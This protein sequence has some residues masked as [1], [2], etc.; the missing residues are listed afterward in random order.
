[1]RKWPSFLLAGLVGT[2]LATPAAAINLCTFSTVG[3]N[4]G[5]YN[6]FSAGALTATGTVT[7]RC[8]GVGG[9]AITIDLSQGTAPSFNPRTMLR[10]GEALNYNLYLDAA[11]TQIWGNG[12]GGSQRYGPLVPQNNRTTDVTIFG[13]IPAGQDVTVGSYTDTIIATINF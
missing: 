5:N 1:M 3:I 4:F 2:C 6:V 12:T 11:A 13:R 8:L 9:E 7:Y 10:S